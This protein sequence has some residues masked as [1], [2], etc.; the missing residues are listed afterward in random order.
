[1]TRTIL[2]LLASALLATTA[3]AQSTQCVAQ[4]GQNTTTING[5]QITTP[6][7][8]GIT[9]ACTNCCDKIVVTAPSG[10]TVNIKWAAAWTYTGATAGADYCSSPAGPLFYY[11]PA[12]LPWLQ[13]TADREV[14]KDFDQTSVSSGAP[15]EVSIC[16]SAAEWKSPEVH[17]DFLVNVTSAAG[18]PLVT[19]FSGT[20]GWDP[21]CTDKGCTLGYWKTHYPESWP[22]GNGLFATVFGV[23]LT[24]TKC[25][26]GQTINPTTTLLQAL[27]MGGGDECALVRQ[28]TAAYLNSLTPGLQPCGQQPWPELG[29]AYDT[30]Q[31]RSM[32]QNA[33]STKNFGNYA[34][35]FG[36]A[37]E[38][39]DVCLNGAVW[40]GPNTCTSPASFCSYWLG[41][42]VPLF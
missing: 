2:V 21:Q 10:A 27:N 8:N 1:M 16:H 40:Q 18:A 9:E 32:V 39:L 3:F 14:Y 5:V 29:Y 33:Y 34:N 13:H 26:K 37:N 12:V 6:G 36:A 41:K 20:G 25:N 28:A 15:I 17:V 11:P 35:L 19:N 22:V 7:N 4:F 38:A 23:T 42:G 30:E 24:G 31:V